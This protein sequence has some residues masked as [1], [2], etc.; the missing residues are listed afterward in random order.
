VAQPDQDINP[1]PPAGLRAA[2]RNTG[3][4]I[5]NLMLRVIEISAAAV[6]RL[7]PLPHIKRLFRRSRDA[8]V[9][10]SLPP[11]EDASPRR[12]RKPVYILA[13][14]AAIIAAGAAVGGTYAV[15]RLSGQLDAAS[16]RD[17]LAKE[18]IPYSEKAF[19][20]CVGAG[21]RRLTAMFLDA[22]MNPNARR[23]GDDATGLHVA[24]SYGQLAVAEL[25]A[26]RGGLVN[27]RDAKGRTPLMVAAERGDVAMVDL[28]L[29]MG[30]DINLTNYAGL[31]ALQIAQ[32]RR[33]QA[34]VARLVRAGAQKGTASGPPQA[35]KLA[36]AIDL[37]SG[38]AKPA[39]PAPA[40]QGPAAAAAPEEP[41]VAAG[42]EF[43]LGPGKAGAIY[44]GM[45]P[46]AIA[47]RLANAR[48]EFGNGYLAGRDRRLAFVYLPGAAISGPSLTIGFAPNG[49]EPA[50]GI[51]IA[52]PRFKTAE[53]LGVGSSLGDLRNVYKTL[54]IEYDEGSVIIAV[55]SQR[56]L[57]ELDFGLNGIP[58]EWLR[59]GNP[60][61]L[62][63]DVKVQRVMVF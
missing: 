3:R 51:S 49:K 32:E 59:T 58:Y 60:A 7:S 42:Q 13:G 14:L 63:D 57:F 26:S 10:N 38:P 31:S 30:A 24:A 61:A 39:V 46:N 23:P 6:R 28:L 22:G 41:P 40:R 18:K 44:I 11:K 5:K 54:A 34:V 2:F 35:A 47:Q 15:F 45:T 36:G 21:D 27:A 17:E 9:I 33:Q 62:P 52:D 48:V 43:L 12:S 20:Q 1:S 25:L 53:G 37:A 4:A 50:I 8:A 16:P 56:L 55:R 29:K 19:F